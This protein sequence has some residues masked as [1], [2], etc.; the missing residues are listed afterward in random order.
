MKL[1]ETAKIPLLSKALNAYATRQKVTSAN[2]ANIN[3]VGYRSQSVSFSSELN[4]AVENCANLAVTNDK[5]I[6]GIGDSP[7]DSGVKIVDAVSAGDIPDDPYASGVNNV[8]IDHEMSE[9]AQN[10]LRFKYAARLMTD[11]FR[12]LQESIKGQQ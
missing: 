2:I 7:D 1:F 3:T 5:H 9:L 6:N 12:R 8:D 10:Q 11:T 4:T